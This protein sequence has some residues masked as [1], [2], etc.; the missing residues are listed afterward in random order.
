VGI[1]VLTDLGTSGGAASFRRGIDA[2]GR[3]IGDSETSTGDSHAFVW[4]HG[5]M[6][7]LGT[8]GG[9]NSGAWDIND[10]G[11]VVGWAETMSGDVHAVIWRRVIP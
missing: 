7:D 1:G 11:E 4:E 6:I 9:N 5:G 10:D 3:V 8:L 2:Q